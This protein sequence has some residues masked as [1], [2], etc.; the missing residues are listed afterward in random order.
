LGAGIPA[1]LFTAALVLPPI[2]ADPAGVTLKTGAASIGLATAWGAIHS[3]LGVGSGWIA[4]ALLG[5]AGLGFGQLLREH[6]AAQA[7]VLGL[8]LTLL[9]L[10]LLRPASVNHPL[11]FARYLLAALPLLLLSVACGADRLLRIGTRPRWLPALGL[12]LLAVAYAWQSPLHQLLATPNS[13]VTHS[14]FQFDFRPAQN[15]VARYQRETLPE[16]PFWKALPVA[17][18]N[19]LQVAAAPFYFETYHWDGPRWEQASGQRVWP[20]FLAGFC[21]DR[22]PGEAPD[23]GRFPLRNAWWLSRIAAGEGPL[24]DWLVFTRPIPRF[25]HTQEG[26]DMRAEFAHC[27]QRLKDLLG[28]A[29]Y[30]D[31]ALLAWQLAP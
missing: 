22:R 27:T 19:S 23:D 11:T 31:D 10:L 15:R 29:D 9:V 18:R 7:I 21:A 16:S 13:H 4:L 3:W 2:I 17:D 6:R 28:P 25:A 30:E 8:F 20:A 24:P 1:G 14:R 5:L 12:A 26:E